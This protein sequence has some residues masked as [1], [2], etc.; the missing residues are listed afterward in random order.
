MSHFVGQFGLSKI[1]A[2]ILKMAGFCPE[3]LQSI[4]LMISFALL[5]PAISG[6]GSLSPAE[7]GE[8]AVFMLPLGILV[9]S[10]LRE[11]TL[12][13]KGL[14]RIRQELLL[15]S[16]LVF[17]F[18]SLILIPPWHSLPYG[19]VYDHEYGLAKEHIGIGS[20]VGIATTACLINLSWSGILFGIATVSSMVLLVVNLDA[21]RRLRTEDQP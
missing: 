9:V 10:W 3:I 21:K 7:I 5:L 8:V 16:A 15:A 12:R 18:Y 4:G 17:S 2:G 1:E 11:L 13:F 19:L 20:T 6:G 14:P